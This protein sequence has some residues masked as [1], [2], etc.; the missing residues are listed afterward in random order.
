MSTANS[1][2]VPVSSRLFGSYGPW[3]WR[4]G[5]GPSARAIGGGV[6]CGAIDPL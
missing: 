3:A 6:D 1:R 5:Y 4:K 2:A